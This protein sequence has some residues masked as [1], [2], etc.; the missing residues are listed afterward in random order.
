MR[1]MYILIVCLFISAYCANSQSVEVKKDNGIADKHLFLSNRL[2]WEESVELTPD[3]PCEV[4]SIQIYYFGDKAGTDT[5][6]IVGM[7]TAGN[8]YPT[9]YIWSYNELI[10]PIIINYDG[11]PGWKT[12]DLK[13]KGL[14]SDGF[15][16]IVVQ[17][18]MKP[19]G[20][21][22][23]TDNDGLLGL[24][25]IGDP[26]TPNA[27][28]YDIQGTIFY[29]STG[30]FLVRLNVKYD[31][32]FSESSA[33]APPPTLVDVSQQA[34][35]SGGGEI[36][37]AD[38]NNDGWDDMFIGGNF[39]EN[40]KNGTFTNV[41]DKLKI[42]AQAVQ[43]A[44]IDNDGDL[45]CYAMV[46]GAFN[47]DLRME[48][49][50]DRIYLNEGG[51][52][53]ELTNN[54]VFN[55][56]YPDPATDFKLGYSNKQDSL[57]NPYNTC[58][59]VWFDIDNDGRLDLY[60]ANKRIEI[61]GKPEIYCP[62]QIWWQENL[63]K[64][65]NIRDVAQ[66]GQGEPYSTQNAGY[67]DCYGASAVDYNNDNYTDIFVATYRIA[68]DNLFK[69]NADFTFTDMASISGAKGSPTAS[70]N[71]YGH[72]MGSDWGDFDNDGDMDLCIGNLAHTDSRGRYSNPSIIFENSGTPD[73][74]FTDKRRSMG[75]KFHEGNAGALWLDLDLDGYL[76]LWHGKYSGGA[77]VFYLNSGSP[78]FKLKDITW[79]ANQVIQNPWVAARIDYDNDGD[80]DML[81]AGKLIRND[82]PRKGNWIAFR[83]SGNPSE[84]VNQN[85]LGSKVKVYANGKMFYRQ[86]AGSA[87]GTHSTQSSFELHFGVGDAQTVDS[88]VIIYS[89]GKINKLESL[90][91]NSSY[92]ISYNQS[93][94]RSILASPA[95]D[96]PSNQSTNI[97]AKP[98]L[99][100]YS[101]G[102][103]DKYII[104]LSNNT[105]FS[106]SAN[107]KTFSFESS[108]TN[109][110]I[111][112]AIDL[113]TNWYWRAK[114]ISGTDT[115][116]W[117]S[118]WSFY[119]G[120]VI[121]SLPQATKPAVNEENVNA[122]ATFSWN[123]ST[124][125][126]FNPPVPKYDIQIS[127][128]IEFST[129]LFE[130]NN[131]SSTSYKSTDTLPAGADL[132]WRVRA[133]DVNGTYDWTSAIP[134]TV[135]PLTSKVQILSPSNGEEYISQRPLFIWNKVPLAKT[136]NLQISKFAN[137][138]ELDYN[139]SDISDS[140]FKVF[141]P[142]L[143]TA[144]IYFWRV[145]G[146]NDGGR[147][148]WSE[149][150]T[151]NTN[152]VPSVIEHLISELKVYPIPA[153]TFLNIEMTLKE[154]VSLIFTLFDERGKT[155]VAYPE[156]HNKVGSFIKTIETKDLPSGFYTLE[157]KSGENSKLVKF[158]VE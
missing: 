84:A 151:F 104:E 79:Q 123:A 35:I 18:F 27:N 36:A 6:H 44:D 146:M 39:F 16:K 40:N 102:S 137:F 119:A 28:F 70:S 98:T 56:P 32:P 17:H 69:N 9:H 81:V 152:V 71:Y 72:G 15:D 19:N 155:L 25:W 133:K 100:W 154:D 23:A 147:G 113:Q 29:K 136:Y 122:L 92:N 95:L 11:I 43:F 60:I 38:W 83:L 130:Y 93:A 105:N 142:R 34:G 53:K 111:E 68:P 107:E 128:N 101:V 21:W 141:S 77:G 88:V 135:M 24:S 91:T 121:P 106:N 42:T 116:A 57:F 120:A 49:T 41:K 115:S 76:D 157:I 131:L 132:F 58:T 145:A 148:A 45:D 2:Y 55:L 138:S 109:L 51:S 86:L 118:V 108:K 78:D 158:V 127:D 153:K 110:D 47:W 112:Q 31:F 50:R 140:S 61:S 37:I 14:R 80:L 63:L 94:I 65:Q 12:I 99:K 96:S 4:E 5:L 75:L 97:P 150:F 156:I 3:G 89:N 59:P 125:S 74:K 22:F 20:P 33:P 67:Y 8:I 54:E 46:H 30:D 64:F 143:D 66:I 139:K 62:D 134:F 82:L 1:I 114:A 87:N 117:S 103:A 7:P 73:Y 13:G 85:A 48:N 126:I 52:F 90:K 10:D 129:I 26:Y 149:V 144:T 124:Y